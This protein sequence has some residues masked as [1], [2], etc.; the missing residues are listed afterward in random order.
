M[1]WRS[2][3]RC[4]CVDFTSAG[5]GFCGCVA[6]LIFLICSG[7][8]FFE[9]LMDL[10]KIFG[11]AASLSVGEGVDLVEGRDVVLLRSADDG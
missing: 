2:W 7:T 1:F 10:V 3:G 5:L 11:S 8:N 6:A 9:A 4:V